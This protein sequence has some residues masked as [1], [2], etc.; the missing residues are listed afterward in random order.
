M[1]PVAQRPSEQAFL[2]AD[3]SR[4]ED[5]LISLALGL[6]MLES[7]L[8]A[9]PARRYREVARVHRVSNPIPLAVL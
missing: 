5:D 4:T 2:R 1:H 7:A 8:D 3:A 6:R 9:I